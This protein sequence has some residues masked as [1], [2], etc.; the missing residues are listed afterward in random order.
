MSTIDAAAKVAQRSHSAPGREPKSAGGEF[1]LLGMPDVNGSIRGKALRPAAFESALRHGTVMTD[2]LLG[3]DPVDTPITDY[4]G[5]GIRSGA[6]DLLVH[7]DPSTLH[8]LIWRPGWRICLATP[9]WPDG[10]T[11]ELASREVL[12]RVVGGLAELGYEALAAVEYELRLW[13]ASDNPLS[14]GLSYSL[15]ELGR[16]DAFVGAL[17]PALDALGVELAAVHTEAAPGLLELNL[18]A[19]PA[20]RAAD[21]AALTKMAVKDL[22][23]TMGL[24]ASFLAKTAPGEEGSSG[25]VHFSCWSDG[26]NAFRVSAGS[27]PLPNLFRSA[28]A[29]V[30]EHLPAASL[31]L[32][33]TINSYKRLVP[34]YFAPVNVSWGVEN[35]SAAVRAIV[36]PAHP[37]LCRLECRRP[38]A[39]ANPYLALAAIVASA[40]D[41]IRRKATPPA[42]VQG[43]AYARD[44]LPELPGSLESALRAFAEDRVLRGLLDERFADYF[45]TSRAWELKA[46]RATVTDWE[47]ERY[48]RTV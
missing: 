14:T 9:S 19:R 38:G 4:T 12:R 47:R 42:P 3:L 29:G 20:L 2:L 6:G 18:S 39:D 26:S 45:A 30:L 44:E 34:G 17:A 27:A 16:F 13:D 32:N 36:S 1:I 35:R 40:A 10:R 31:L 23:A 21:D 28:I 24:R 15:S 11:C 41:G 25:H 43:D 48:G 46:W 7:P 8:D 33:P 5:F 37:E 22:A